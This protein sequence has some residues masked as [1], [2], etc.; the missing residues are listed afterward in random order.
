MFVEDGSGTVDI[1]IELCYQAPQSRKLSDPRSWE[2]V[3]TPKAVRGVT[4][5]ASI[6]RYVAFDYLTTWGK[7][8]EIA[9]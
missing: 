3:H 6:D 8:I 7:Q 2:V 1:A 4:T 9:A 5:L